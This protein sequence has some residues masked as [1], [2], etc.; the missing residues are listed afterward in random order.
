MAKH[1]ISVSFDEKSYFWIVVDNG[2]FIRNPTE[3]D[4]RDA[5]LKEYNKTNICEICRMVN[6]I[7]DKSIL[8]PKNAR[9]FNINGKNVWCCERHRD[10]Y[11]DSRY[12]MHVSIEE[13]NSFWVIID[14]GMLIRNPTEDC[15]WYEKY[16]VKDEE[17]LKKA[18]EIWAQLLKKR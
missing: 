16:R 6:N 1:K 12:K 18:N 5:K 3:D 11:K 2:K 17:E 13:D 15:G 7:I 10:G 8:Y 4:L 9:Q 14:R